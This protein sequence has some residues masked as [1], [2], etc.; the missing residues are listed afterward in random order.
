METYNNG[1]IDLMLSTKCKK[2]LKLSEFKNIVLGE[3]VDFLDLK[4]KKK[5]D[6][7][8]SF[9]GFDYIPYGEID[10]LYDLL[11]KGNF[12]NDEFSNFINTLGDILKNDS[13]LKCCDYQKFSLL[14]KRATDYQDNN[15]KT[16]VLYSFQINDILKKLK[17]SYAECPNNIELLLS[18]VSKCT[19]AVE[20]K[21]DV[22]E[23][24]KL[25]HEQLDRE[26][27]KFIKSLHNKNRQSFEPYFS[28]ITFDKDVEQS[29]NLSLIKNTL[30]KT[31]SFFQKKNSK[32]SSKK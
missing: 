2:N 25:Y 5:S 23:I 18:N 29:N 13:F 22:L 26:W 1:N 4:D 17:E 15:K 32:S 8:F 21:N 28:S 14:L 6:I 27:P 31:Y 10:V 19:N 30:S 9:D 24:S 12:D 11:T 7:L 20:H 16:S 3:Y